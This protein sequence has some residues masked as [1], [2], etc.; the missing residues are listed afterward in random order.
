MFK[1]ICGILR[2]NEPRNFNLE[3]E[4]CPLAGVEAIDFRKQHGLPQAPNNKIELPGRMYENE[5]VARRFQLDN[6]ANVNLE[7]IHQ[8]ESYIHQCGSSKVANLKIITNLRS[9]NGGLYKY[10]V[11][12]PE[13]IKEY[14]EHDC[15]GYAEKLLKDIISYSERS[16][17]KAEAEVYRLCQQELEQ[18]EAKVKAVDDARELLRDELMAKD[19]VIAA[20]NAELESLRITVES[21]DREIEKWKQLYNEGFKEKLIIEKQKKLKPVKKKIVAEKK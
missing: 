19:N 13:I 16:K 1:I 14:L 6:E 8:W 10:P 12:A 9:V 2:N 17:T 20:R 4:G 21:K 18:R 15:I 5:T 3:I 7:Y 11:A